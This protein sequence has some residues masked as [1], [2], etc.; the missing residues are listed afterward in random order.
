MRSNGAFTFELTIIF[1]VYVTIIWCI[2]SV[3][4]T[5]ASP[6]A[7]ERRIE[8]FLNNGNSTWW[9]IV[10]PSQSSS[11]GQLLYIQPVN[12]DE[13]HIHSCYQYKVSCSS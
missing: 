3:P 1:L 10:D 2:A 8:E 9:Q 6:I 13:G 4:L 11:S 12:L 7:D 5:Q